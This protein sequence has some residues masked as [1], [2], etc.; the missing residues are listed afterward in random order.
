MPSSTT[1]LLA[2]PEKYMQCTLRR[3]YLV[4]T[5]FIRKATMPWVVSNA[6]APAQG[7]LFGA[8]ICYQ[9]LLPPPPRNPMVTV[10]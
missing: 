9:H 2:D 7:R 4:G 6:P 1:L 8:S 10:K 3:F 5:H